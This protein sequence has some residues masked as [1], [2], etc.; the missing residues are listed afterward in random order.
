MSIKVL[1]TLNRVE[2][3]NFDNMDEFNQYYALN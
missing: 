3:R 2:P 1:K